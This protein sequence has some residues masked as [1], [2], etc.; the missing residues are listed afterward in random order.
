MLPE[1]SIFQWDTNQQYGIFHDLL[2]IKLFLTPLW[3]QPFSVI[4]LH[5][6]GICVCMCVCVCVCVCVCTLVEFIAYKDMNFP[7]SLFKK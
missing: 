4:E 5:Q 1:L 2:L 3:P 7:N 6:Q